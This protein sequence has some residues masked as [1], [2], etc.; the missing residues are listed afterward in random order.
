MSLR[1]PTS[2]FYRRE[3]MTVTKRV[4]SQLLAFSR[5]RNEDAILLKDAA[6]HINTVNKQIVT[7][8]K[9]NEFLHKQCEDLKEHIRK[10]TEGKDSTK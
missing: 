7:L 8:R 3:K 4:V 6:Y 10:L 5:V 1:V 2:F 9:E